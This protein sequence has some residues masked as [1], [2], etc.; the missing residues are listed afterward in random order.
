MNLYPWDAGTEE[1]A[2]FSL[3]NSPTS[4]QGVI[5]SLRGTGKFSNEPIATL[6]FTRQSVNTAPELM[7]TA[8]PAAIVEAGGSATVTVEITNGVTFEEDQEIA[9]AFAGTATKGTDYTVALESLTLTAGE[10]SVAT[11]VRAVQD[12]VD[13]DAETILITASHGGGAI[14]AEQTITI[15]DDDA[16]PSLVLSVNAST[17]DE[18]GG[19]AAVTVSTGSG[20]TYATAQTVRL[21]VAGTATENVDYTISG[22]TL[23]LPA[24]VGTGASMVTATVTGVDDNLD[25]DDETVE[26]TGSRN[27]VAF[28]SRQTIAIDDDDWPELTVAFRQ[29]D[30]RVA[31]GAH[32]DLPVTLS[33]APERQVTIPIEIEVAGGAE[34]VDYSVSPTSVTFEAGETDS[35]LRV[36]ASNDSAVDPGESVALSLGTPLPERISEGGIAETTVAI[37]DTDFT[38]APAFA[39]GAGTTESDTDVY[40]VSEASSALR[41]SLTLQT[42]RGAR[43]VDIVDPVVVTLATR[44][45]AGNRG[46]DED[47]ATERRSGTFGDYGEL[48]PGPVV[49]PGRFLGRCDLRLRA[50]G[51]VG[52]GG[53]LRRPGA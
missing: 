35:S 32:V 1:G 14:G 50:G 8:S 23:T 47:Y 33:A 22:R 18:D 19:T 39:A 29:A 51:E 46:M 5:T 52:V 6:T 25:D 7:L 45:N 24:G 34:A 43:V 30:Y 38:F 9:L 17:I 20:S 16:T 26:I 10:S 28:G 21:A 2:E 53:H 27:G 42:P 44:E 40:A 31:E 41:L 36:R 13:D 4:P 37:R 48:R 3:S 49:R 12:R 15:I 11:T